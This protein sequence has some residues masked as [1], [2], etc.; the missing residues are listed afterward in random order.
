MRVAISQPTYLPW[1]G[2]F[3]LIDQVDCFVVLDTV[4]FEKQSWQQRNR[5][6]TPTGL[7]WLTLPVSFRGRLGQCINHVEIR[8]ADFCV[9][10]LRAVELSYRRTPF[11]EAHYA[12][13]SG[14]LG[15]VRSGSRLLN[16]NLELLRWFLSEFG[17]STRLVLASELPVKG[18]RTELLANICSH[19]EASSYLSP[20]GSAAY[21]LDEMQIMTDRE[22]GVL[23]Q[24]Y[25]HPEYAQ[26]FP[27][28]CPY[29]SALD[30]LFNE[31]PRSLEII[32]SGR[33]TS[34]APSQAAALTRTEA[35]S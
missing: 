1:L 13:L 33:R 32:R 22:I 29:A 30:L 25:E 6:K 10:H 28:F 2:Y 31:G 19:Q 18:K 17:I 12:M 14:I 4:Q 26:L 27:P 8:E 5:I 3:D 20:L 35:V 16:L 21:L 15:S 24:H 9:K 11:F 7:Q 23:F 34:Y